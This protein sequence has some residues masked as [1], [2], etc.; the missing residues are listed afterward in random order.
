MKISVKSDELKKK[1]AAIQGIVVPNSKEPILEHFKLVAEK[2]G[3]VIIATDNAVFLQ[4]PIEVQVETEGTYCLPRKVFEI[5]K[6]LG[7]EIRMQVKDK[8]LSITSGKNKFKVPVMNATEFPLTSPVAGVSIKIPTAEMIDIINKTIFSC[9]AMQNQPAMGNILFKTANDIF[10]VV[11][12][13]GHRLAAI[14]IKK[15]GLKD[16]ISALVP[17]KA[18]AELKKLLT[19]AE[20]LTMV[21]GSRKVQFTI[22]SVELY[23]RLAE[24]SFPSYQQVIP[25]NNENVVIIGRNSLISSI[26]KAKVMLGESSRSVMMQ[27][28]PDVVTFSSQNT[29]VGEF[30]TEVEAD[31]I[32][33]PMTVSFNPDYLLDALGNMTTEQVFIRFN[34][35]VSPTLITEDGNDDYKYVVMPMNSK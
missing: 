34:N 21:I 11:A 3:S 2:A 4:E 26:K 14:E 15:E 35:E 17:R 29:E 19:G 8:S 31:F 6:E 12:T 22:G 1:L 25:K 30:K 10:E 20:T 32:G 24:G 7:D 27:L 13:N 5:A 18:L 9:E 33:Q 23:V 16:N 28:A